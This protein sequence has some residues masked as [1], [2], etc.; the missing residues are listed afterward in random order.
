[1]KKSIV[2]S[3]RSEKERYQYNNPN[4]KKSQNNK[5]PKNSSFGGGRGG[6]RRHKVADQHM[7]STCWG[8][9]S[10]RQHVDYGR[11]N[12]WQLREAGRPLEADE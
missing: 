12:G 9:R 10:T 3:F 5:N 7:R 4:N 8:V 6:G 11:Q 1:M 2:K